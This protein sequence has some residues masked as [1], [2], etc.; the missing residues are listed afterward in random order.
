M[1]L[2]F[3]R[4]RYLA[5]TATGALGLALRSISSEQLAA[6]PL[7][8]LDTQRLL[9]LWMNGGP[10]QLETLDPKPGSEQGGPTKSIATTAD[11]VRIGEHLPKL[12]RQLHH[13]ALLRNLSSPEGAHERAQYL[14]HTGF[15]LQP[16]FPR[17]TLGSVVSRQFPPAPFPKFVSFGQQRFGPAFLGSLHQAWAIGDPREALSRLRALRSRQRQLE[18]LK[19]LGQAFADSRQQPVV[20]ERDAALSRIESMLSTGFV[21]ALDVEQEAAALERYG[22]HRFGRQCLAARRLLEAGVRCVEVQLDGWDTHTNNFNATRRLCEQLDS[23]WAAL[24]EDLDRSGLLAET[25]VLWLGEFG[26]TPRINSN[27]GRDH[28]PQVTPVALA[29]GAVRGG[30][31]I[32][33]TDSA[34][35]PAGQQHSVADLFATLLKSIGLAADFKFTTDFGSPTAATDQGS[36]IESLL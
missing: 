19:L 27:N 31:A 8:R 1:S 23:P 18:Q 34:G 33:S 30:Q 7:A 4:R 32:G 15:A 5:A 20:A 21:D 26:R 16:N 2:S 36:P 28:F 24:L 25:T 22:D 13:V 10:S 17:P 9:V 3:H 29:G 11:G 14:L 6:A 12:A 35:A